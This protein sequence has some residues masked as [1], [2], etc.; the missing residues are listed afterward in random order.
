M[1]QI[2]FVKLVTKY[3][4]VPVA[5]GA[6]VLLVVTL[7]ASI[8]GFNKV[9]AVWYE[10]K[11][12][13]AEARAAIAEQNAKVLEQDAAQATLA[14]AILNNVVI[15]Q[16]EVAARQRKSTATAV[17]V[18]HERIVKVPVSISPPVDPVVFEQVREAAAR[19]AAASNRLSGTGTH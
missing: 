11:A 16:H 3:G 10:H 17:E 7:F 14:A 12:E 13:K 6:F 19:T 4:V 9:K 5:F 8:A 15:K 1:I 18:I 2:W